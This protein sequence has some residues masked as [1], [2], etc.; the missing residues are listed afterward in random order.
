[1]AILRRCYRRIWWKHEVSTY[2]TA[3]YARKHT[4]QSSRTTLTVRTRSYLQHYNSAITNNH[5]SG[6]ITYSKSSG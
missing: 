6:D 3:S 4:H 1:M 2:G 5:F